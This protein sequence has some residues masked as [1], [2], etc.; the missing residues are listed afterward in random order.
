MREKLREKLRKSHRKKG[1]IREKRQEK[2]ES[3]EMTRSKK[4]KK[5]YVCNF[6]S[7]KSLAR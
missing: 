3:L 4:I 5:T 6:F 2:R 7:F 1:K